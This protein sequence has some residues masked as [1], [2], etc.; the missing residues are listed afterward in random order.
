MNTSAT[1]LAIASDPRILERK[2]REFL[3]T[4][5]PIQRQKIRLFNFFMPEIMIFKDG[6]IE[7]KWPAELLRLESEYDKIIEQ[8]AQSVFGSAIPARLE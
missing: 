5:E 7:T 6:R 2:R 3:E 1:D 8:Y 4:I